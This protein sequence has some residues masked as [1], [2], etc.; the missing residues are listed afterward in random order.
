MRLQ[1]IDGV[2]VEKEE[3]LLATALAPYVAE[4]LRAGWVLDTVPNPNAH[5]DMTLAE[6]QVRLCAFVYQARLCAF[7][8]QVRLCAFVYASRP[9]SVV[10]LGRCPCGCLCVCVCALHL[11]LMCMSLY[12]A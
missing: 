1:R 6:Y 9:L 4:A 3:R 12:D 2:V 10:G 5:L 8:Y 11:Q 7:V